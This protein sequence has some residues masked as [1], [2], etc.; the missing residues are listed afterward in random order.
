MLAN[1]MCGI[2]AE[3]SS[4]VTAS[5]ID[6]AHR[7]QI[8]CLRDRKGKIT[9]VTDHR[10]RVHATIQQVKQHMGCHIHV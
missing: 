1:A 9:I 8:P 2:A 5:R 3:G 7:H 10:N 6:H 4:N